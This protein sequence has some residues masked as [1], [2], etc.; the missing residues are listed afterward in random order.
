MMTCEPLRLFV[1]P[2]A[3]P[4]AVHKPALVPIYWRGKVYQDLEK[5]CTTGRTAESPP[6]Y[7]SHMVLQD[8]NHPK[9]DVPLTCNLKIAVQSGKPTMYQVHFTWLIA[10]HRT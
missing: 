5:R 2:N 4:V 1:D 8:G 3:K 10:F 9:S 7:A 6:E